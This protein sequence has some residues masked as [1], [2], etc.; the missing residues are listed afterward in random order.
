MG[1]RNNDDRHWT[2]NALTTRWT[3]T[4]Y[5]ERTG[6]DKTLKKKKNTSGVFE[7]IMKSVVSIFF[8]FFLPVYIFY[9][10]L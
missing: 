7:Q 1:R 6:P 9:F 5:N 2:I 3:I 4:L 8:V 10:N